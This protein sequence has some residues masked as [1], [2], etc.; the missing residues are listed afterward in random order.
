MECHLHRC[1]KT[2]AVMVALSSKRQDLLL[3]YFCLCSDLTV[4]PWV[5]K[6]VWYR[7]RERD[8]KVRDAEQKEGR[9]EREDSFV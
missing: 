3:V 9:G 2:I 7:K 8:R 1:F 6:N 5:S 4:C